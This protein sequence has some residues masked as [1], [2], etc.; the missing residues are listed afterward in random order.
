MNSFHE[1]PGM[2][3]LRGRKQ[4]P[5]QCVKNISN[6]CV[7]KDNPTR[8]GTRLVQKQQ[9]AR[10]LGAHIALFWGSLRREQHPHPAGLFHAPGLL[11]GLLAE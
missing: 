3:N 1:T 7:K 5:F 9:H 11:S 4:A 6:Q 8:K 10:R 2:K